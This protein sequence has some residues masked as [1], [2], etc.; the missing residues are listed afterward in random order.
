MGACNIGQ[1]CP[2]GWI[3]A[4]TPASTTGLALLKPAQVFTDPPLPDGVFDGVRDA[5]STSTTGEVTAP[6]IAD[7]QLGGNATSSSS[8]TS[9][10]RGPSRRWWR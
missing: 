1:R 10:W 2:F 8:T 3:V 5:I 9:I 6:L 4:V 7:A